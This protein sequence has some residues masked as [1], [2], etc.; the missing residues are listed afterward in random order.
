MGDD[1]V[2]VMLRIKLHLLRSYLVVGPLSFD[3]TNSS[4]SSPT[5]KLNP[6]SWTKVRLR[7]N[8]F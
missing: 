2:Y 3:Y 4:Q 7:F 1:D 6:Y 5:F 8:L